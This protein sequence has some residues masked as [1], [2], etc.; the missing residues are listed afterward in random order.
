MVRLLTK[1]KE[2]HNYGSWNVSLPI[3][4]KFIYIFVFVFFENSCFWQSQ[5]LMETVQIDDDDDDDAT[6]LSDATEIN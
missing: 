6:F 3:I 1:A 2:P 4:M 5:W